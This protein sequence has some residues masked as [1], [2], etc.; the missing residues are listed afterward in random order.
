MLGVVCDG[1]SVF[2]VALYRV[3]EHLT[4]ETE[5]AH[6]PAGVWSGPGRCVYINIVSRRDISYPRRV[7][8]EMEKTIYWAEQPMFTVLAFLYSFLNL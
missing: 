1:A 7:W 3:A 8:I 2:V 4:S 5:Y 6:S